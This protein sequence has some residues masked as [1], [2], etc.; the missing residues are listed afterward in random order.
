MEA[1]L[2][3]FEGDIGSICALLMEGKINLL[4]VL[5]A[6]SG[7]LV[8]S[9]AIPMIDKVTGVRLWRFELYVV[10]LERLFIRS[11]LYLKRWLFMQGTDFISCQ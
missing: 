7:K 3:I 4:L 5:R 1:K 2:Y 8:V 6:Y 9:D 10:G 11:G